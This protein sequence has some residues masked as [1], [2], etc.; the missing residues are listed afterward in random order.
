[1]QSDSVRTGTAVCA[2]AVLRRSDCSIRI[3]QASNSVE[4]KAQAYGRLTLNTKH[5]SCI[6]IT[7]ERYATCPVL[8]T[9]LPQHVVHRHTA[10]QAASEAA[11]L[12]Q[13]ATSVRCR[14]SERH[15]LA[16]SNPADEEP[17]STATAARHL[18]GPQHSASSAG[19]TYASQSV[20]QP[21]SSRQPPGKQPPTQ[22][23]QTSGCNP[24][25]IP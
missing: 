9:L 24:D 15:P 11:T 17:C 18:L 12:K 21:A 6:H 1:M 22:Q 19:N 16:A 10:A 14:L 13:P 2:V 8:H 7:W 5:S 4:A 23:Y 20:S 3:M 25:C